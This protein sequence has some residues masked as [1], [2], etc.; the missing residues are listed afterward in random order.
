MEDEVQA[1]VID[2]GSVCAKPVSPVM[3]HPALC[4]HPL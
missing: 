4:S 2:N 3:M 1:L